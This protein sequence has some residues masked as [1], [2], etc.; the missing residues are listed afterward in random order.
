MILIMDYSSWLTHK[1][2]C[3]HLKSNHANLV[4]FVF[5]LARSYLEVLNYYLTQH[6]VRHK[7]L[8]YTITNYLA[9]GL[10]DLFV[11]LLK[12]LVSSGIY[13]WP[14][15]KLITF[16]L[17]DLLSSIVCKFSDRV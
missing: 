9:L 17:Y 14:L 10:P 3:S 16:K 1:V 2:K 13:I 4:Q 7:D 11:L 5:V 12:N 8:H 6:F 15:H